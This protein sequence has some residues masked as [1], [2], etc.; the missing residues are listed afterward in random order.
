MLIRGL[1]RGVVSVDIVTSGHP[2]GTDTHP[3]VVQ[4]I[5][6]DH[7]RTGA[8]SAPRQDGELLKM[9]ILEIDQQHNDPRYRILE[10]GCLGKGVENGM[11]LL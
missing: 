11:P 9:S 4:S 8:L 7:C 2:V 3:L 10:F 1:A 6:I 5:L